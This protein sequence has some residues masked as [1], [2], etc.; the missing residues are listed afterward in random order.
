MAASQPR[1]REHEG[2]ARPGYRR[3]VNAI[4]F[5]LDGTITDSAP[6][7]IDCFQH[8]LAAVG[9]PPADQDVLRGVVGPPIVH[10]FERLGMDQEQI[11][12]ARAAYRARYDE[13]GWAENSVFPGMAELLERQGRSGIPLGVATSKN[14]RMAR[15]IL[16][17]FGL[18]EPFAFIGGASDDDTRIEKADVIVHSLGGLGL[19]VHRAE[20]GGTLGVLLVGDRKHDVEG[21]ARYGIPTVLVSWGYGTPQ[22]RAGARW[23]VDTPAELGELLDQLVGD[24][25]TGGAQH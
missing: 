14:E 4:L 18:A 16:R 19:P 25:V 12:T 9:F 11:R 23:S 22:E 7:I 3:R 20:D 13:R 15:H 5:D 24:V 8:A 2:C 17:H 1:R 6:G 10:T 21:A